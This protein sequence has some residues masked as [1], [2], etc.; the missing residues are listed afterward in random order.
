MKTVVVEDVIGFMAP[1]ISL[2]YLSSFPLR[3]LED[4]GVRCEV[5]APRM[6]GW[7]DEGAPLL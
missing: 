4:E 1:E 5:V 7:H 2:L 3:T 6:S